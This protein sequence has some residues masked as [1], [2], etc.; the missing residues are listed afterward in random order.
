[1]LSRWVFLHSHTQN[2]ENA[3][4]MDWKLYSGKKKRDWMT[5]EV[6]W[7]KKSNECKKEIDE[8]EKIATRKLGPEKKNS[9][10]FEKKKN[11]TTVFKLLFYSIYI[12]LLL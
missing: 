11:V 9:N 8:T 12:E 10:N 3:A 1:M 4:Y 5:Q 2:D 6:T 7:N